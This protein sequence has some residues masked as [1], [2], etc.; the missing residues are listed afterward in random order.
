MNTQ[1]LFLFCLLVYVLV[2]THIKYIVHAGEF[3]RIKGN[4]YKYVLWFMDI[5]I[6]YFFD[7][8]KSVNNS[9]R[10]N[11]NPTHQRYP[12]TD[13]SHNKSEISTCTKCESHSSYSAQQSF[14][15]HELGHKI[16]ANSGKLTIKSTSEWYNFPFNNSPFFFSFRQKSSNEN[17]EI[18]KWMKGGSFITMKNNEKHENHLVFAANS[19]G[20]I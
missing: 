20:A 19:D 2:H 13:K 4:A 10:A 16:K 12:I 14:W 15:F 8:R 11:R 17:A 5:Y 3:A 1:Q 9:K 18:N 7:F 6:L